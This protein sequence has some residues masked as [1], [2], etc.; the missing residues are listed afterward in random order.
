MNLSRLNYSKFKVNFFEFSKLRV[1]L[2]NCIKNFL[3]RDGF[4]KIDEKYVAIDGE[5]TTFE[6]LLA[7]CREN[8]SVYF[9]S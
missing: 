6:C 3:D 5:T 4:C 7:V 1:A 8:Y 2:V 9:E